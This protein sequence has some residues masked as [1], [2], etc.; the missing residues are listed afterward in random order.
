MSTNNQVLL[1]EIERGLHGPQKD[2]WKERCER[3]IL[4]APQQIEVSKVE[5]V[6]ITIPQR[7]HIFKVEEKFR[8]EVIGSNIYITSSFQELLGNK[9]EDPTRENILCC[10]ES[11]R[12]GVDSSIISVLGGKSSETGLYDLFFLLTT[13]CGEKYLSSDGEKPN[14]FYTRTKKG[15]CCFVAVSWARVEWHISAFLD[16]YNRDWKDYRVFSRGK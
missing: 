8:S 10:R 3:V 16:I 12:E 9:I 13:D 1:A 15:E 2:W 11:W 7:F 6:L 5:D 4:E 14:V